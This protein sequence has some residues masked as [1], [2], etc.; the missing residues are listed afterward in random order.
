M[1][2]TTLATTL[3]GTG[4]PVT[5]SLL[6]ALRDNLDAFAT[7]L[8]GAPVNTA[9]WHPYDHVTNGDGN[10]GVLYDFDVDGAITTVTTP[11]FVDGWEYQLMF[12]AI[13]TG[14]ATLT[15]KVWQETTGSYTAAQTIIPASQNSTGLITLPFV[16]VLAKT[17]VA[18]LNI[19]AA[20]SM[21]VAG[22]SMT[23]REK[24]TK[25]QL[26]TSGTF[27]KGKIK[28]YRRLAQYSS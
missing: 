16:R 22:Y 13:E 17:Q 18:F 27:A 9:A 11:N 4:K 15:M 8:S 23:A 7:N 5:A 26:V 1:S 28:M 6:Q 20:P 24:V 14:A 12:N 10:T 19:Y 21:T 3:F 2:W 25:V